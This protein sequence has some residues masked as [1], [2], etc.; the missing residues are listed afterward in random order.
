MTTQPL[1]RPDARLCASVES[2]ASGRVAI[3][4]MLDDLADPSRTAAPSADVYG[5]FSRRV[6][7]QT[8]RLLRQI[9]PELVQGQRPRHESQPLP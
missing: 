8:L 5:S 2:A 4:A 3:E 9:P 1:Q 7:Q 6:T